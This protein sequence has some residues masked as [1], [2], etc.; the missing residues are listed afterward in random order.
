[1]YHIKPDK[2]SRAS[3]AE[4]LC[5]LESCLKTMPLS[6]VTVSDLYRATG[7][8]RATFYRL[9]DTVEDAIR[10][11]L[12]CMMEQTAEIWDPLSA[13]VLEQIFTLSKQHHEF[14]SALVENGR[15]DLLFQYTERT[16]QEMDSRYQLFPP[17]MEETERG[18]VMTQLSMNMVAALIFWNRNGKRE[19]FA[20][21]TEYLRRYVQILTEMFEKK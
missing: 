12:D 6:K 15:L 3:A 14:L 7:I 4:I 1:M 11:K 16:F 18:Y 8:S 2:R 20:E 17:D 9:F 13:S 21:E 5:G 19:S 10:Y